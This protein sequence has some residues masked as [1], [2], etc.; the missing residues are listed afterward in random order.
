MR[1]HKIMLLLIAVL[2]VLPGCDD[3]IDLED[4]S[5]LLMLGIDLDKDNNLVFYSSSPVFNKEAKE[6]MSKPKCIPQL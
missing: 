1:L 6:K 4:I 2:L 5:L 3:R